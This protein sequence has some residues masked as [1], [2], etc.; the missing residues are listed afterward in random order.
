MKRRSF[1]AGLAAGIASLFAP[2]LRKPRLPGVVYRLSEP[3]YIGKFPVHTELTILPADTPFR[4]I[5]FCTWENVLV[6]EPDEL[7][8]RDWLDGDGEEAEIEGDQCRS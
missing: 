2:S 6:G 5:T 4:P 3:H 1:F 7:D 8:F